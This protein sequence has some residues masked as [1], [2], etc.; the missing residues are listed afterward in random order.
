M[1]EEELKSSAPKSSH[2]P[3]E[4]IY[5]DIEAPPS[6]RKRPDKLAKPGK[7]F[8]NA[9]LH[10]VF[11]KD[12]FR[13][14]LKKQHEI[15]EDEGKGEH[16]I[17]DDKIETVEISSPLIEVQIPVEDMPT[18]SEKEDASKEVEE[19]ASESTVK[20]ETKEEKKVMFSQSTEEYQQKLEAERNLVKEDVSLLHQP[21]VDRRWSNMRYAL[22]REEVFCQILSCSNLFN[23]FSILKRSRI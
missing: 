17:T 20:K 6:E 11:N 22:L 14:S 23:F 8:A 9:V 5:E 1:L 4:H 21:Q 15:E 19:H 7:N 18:E 10:S 16:E 13:R 3:K 2:K 12:Q